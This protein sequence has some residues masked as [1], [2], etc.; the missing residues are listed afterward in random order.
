MADI[1]D[2]RLQKQARIHFMKHNL[3]LTMADVRVTYGVCFVTGRMRKMPKSDVKNVEQET[4]KVCDILKKVSGMKEVILQNC[5]FDE[6]QF[7]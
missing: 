7:K 6:E 3:D 5:T 4:L 1:N 2:V